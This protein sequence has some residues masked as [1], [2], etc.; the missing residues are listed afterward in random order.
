M[1][2]VRIPSSCAER[3]TRMAISLRLA[4]RILRKGFRGGSGML[5]RSYG[6]TDDCL[7]DSPKP[8]RGER[9]QAIVAIVRKYPREQSGGDPAKDHPPLPTMRIAGI[10]LS[11]LSG[12]K[13]HCSRSARSASWSLAAG[14]RCR[15]G[16]FLVHARMGR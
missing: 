14:K 5:N 13:K 12:N 15:L 7:A 16:R 3:K 9:E 10:V 11:N 4:A 1:A 6:A 8:G 2:T